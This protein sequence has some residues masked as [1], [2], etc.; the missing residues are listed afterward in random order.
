MES[1]ADFWCGRQDLNLHTLVPEPK[2]GV[3]ANFTTPACVGF[4]NG[5]MEKWY[6]FLKE[7]SI[8]AFSPLVHC[9]MIE[10]VSSYRGGGI[11]VFSVL[12]KN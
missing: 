7:W 9:I 1:F 6:H 3:S 11:W 4:L 12:Q 10:G 8:S 2:S 5:S